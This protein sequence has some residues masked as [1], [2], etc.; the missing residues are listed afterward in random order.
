MMSIEGRERYFQLIKYW[1]IRLE[2]QMGS[3]ENL[4][5][6]NRFAV[7]QLQLQHVELEFASSTHCELV[8]EH[9]SALMFFF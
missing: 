5:P 1:Q 6:T 2:A 3:S 4:P 9:F 7:K 8:E